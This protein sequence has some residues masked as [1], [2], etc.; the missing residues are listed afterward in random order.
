MTVNM[1]VPTSGS[2]LSSRGVVAF[3]GGG[4]GYTSVLIPAQN[5][6]AA[7]S[8]AKH[9]AGTANNLPSDRNV[10]VTEPLTLNLPSDLPAALAEELAPL[11]T[12]YL[13]A[14]AARGLPEDIDEATLRVFAISPF[15]AEIA[16]R[17]PADFRAMTGAETT[18]KARLVADYR[19]LV[20]A[21]LQPCDDLAGAKRALRALRQIEMARI[22]WRDIHLG[23]DLFEVTGELSAFAD[24]VVGAAVAWLGEHL[25]PRFGRALNAAGETL[26]LL[27]IGMGKLGG[28]ELNFSSDIDLI[29]VYGESGTTVGGRKELSHQ[30]YFDRLGREFIGLLNE[31]TADGFVFRVD[32]RLRPFGDS[33]PLCASLNGLEQYYA[34][35]GRDWERYALIKARTITGDKSTRA[36][37]ADLI[38]PFVFRRYLDF[39]ALDALR[40]MKQAI[41]REAASSA[42]AGDVK[43]GPGGI[44]EIE[45]TG[46]LFQLIRGG[47]ERRL[48]ARSLMAVFEACVALGL[49]E[50]A[51]VTLLHASYRFLRITEH[52]LQQV[53]D[54]QT[55]SLPTDAVNRVRLAYALGFASWAEFEQRLNEH[56]HATRSLFAAMLETP[57]A[58]PVE[59]DGMLGGWRDLWLSG[60]EPDVLAEQARTLAGDTFSAAHVNSLLDLKSERFLARLSREGRARLDRLMPNLLARVDQRALSAAGFKR[61]VGLLHTIGR[62]SVYVAFLND[63]PAALER[64]LELFEASP[65]IAEQMIAQPL[66]LDELL[67]QRTLYAPPAEARLHELIAAQVRAEDG[68]EQAMEALRAFRNQQVLRVAASDITDHFPIAEVS[69]QLTY[70]AEACIGAALNVAWDE[71]AAR[72][73]EPCCDDG[74]G[75][76]PAGFAI[77]AYG[78]LGGLELGYG[79]D[80]DLVF[81]NN[82]TGTAQHTNGAKTIDNGVFFTRLAHRL[83]HILATTTPSGVAYEIDTRLRPSG[84]AGMMVLPTPA[85][86]EYLSDKAWV[87]EHQALVRARAVAGTEAVRD[88]FAAIRT[89]VLSRPRDAAELKS[90]IGAMRARMQGELDRSTDLLF[91]LKQGAG[92]ITD[93]EF[94]VQYAVLRWASTHPPLLV[95]TDNLRLLETIARLELL[96]AETCQR[97]H[98]AY[99]AYRADIH[100]CTLQQI[101][102]LVDADRHAEHRSHVT[103]I[104]KR[105]FN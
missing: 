27:V 37:L 71:L 96:D 91:D 44:R 22:A 90:E 59:D 84:S 29:F 13:E 68:L 35:H 33:G 67:D 45:F 77:I 76:R 6:Y 50:R 42:M 61:I 94:M 18:A 17:R 58:A 78:K 63:N 21:T 30:D 8:A 62:R 10:I 92:G 39:G 70:I 105:L 11:A 24:A 93:I 73:G 26:E 53:H 2:L 65:W 28:R 81:L 98:D 104:W 15:V 7:P 31:A 47:R 69:N 12:R 66:L 79:S 99:F 49:L 34:V 3:M 89:E 25:A 46:Q 60:A 9:N 20:D 102:S 101:E 5:D 41:N 100:R 88:D 56:R 23:A 14:Q 40:E 52:R 32:M 43:R 75:V 4:G 19:A 86:R 95:W 83:I 85:F 80:L 51:E 57:G 103:E 82:S 38:R 36:A 87:W 55:H 48:R 97:L 16:I 64:L 54:W 1:V 74:S 72:F